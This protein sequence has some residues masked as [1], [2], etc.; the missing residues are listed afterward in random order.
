M[1]HQSQL[2]ALKWKLLM[3]SRI[4]TAISQDLQ[5]EALL[6]IRVELQGIGLTH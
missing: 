1:N 3:L 5:S 6:K 4:E 2:F